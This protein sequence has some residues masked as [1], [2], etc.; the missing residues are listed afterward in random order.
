[1]QQGGGM[2]KFDNGGQ[3]VMLC[4]L[5]PQSARHQEQQSGANPLATR[6]NDVLRHGAD[7]GHTRVEPLDD[8]SVDGLHVGSDKWM[9]SVLG[10]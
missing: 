4:S 8:H 5:V 6:S 9:G 2:Y 10:G 3:V 1:M 7:Q